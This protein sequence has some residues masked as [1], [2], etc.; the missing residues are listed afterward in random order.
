MKGEVPSKEIVS[1]LKTSKNW[2]MLFATVDRLVRGR[3]RETLL[4]LKGEKSQI[5]LMNARRS[6]IFRTKRH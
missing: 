4:I 5:C 2:Q 3:R 1:V 6:V